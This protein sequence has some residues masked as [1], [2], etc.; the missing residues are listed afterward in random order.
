MPT[1]VSAATS[2][3][4]VRGRSSKGVV[5]AGEPQRLAE[6]AWP[7]AEQPFILEA[8]ALPHRP[9]PVGRLERAYENRFG[10]SFRAADEVQAPVDTVRAVD[11]GVAGRTEHG[12]VAARPAAVGMASGIGVMVRLDLDDR[13]AD[14]VDQEGGADQVRRDHVHRA[15][16]EVS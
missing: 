9:H 16:E 13:A 10:D 8:S 4:V 6:P 12:R 2:T 11:V 15:R 5:L 14:A 1:R 7:R 3:L